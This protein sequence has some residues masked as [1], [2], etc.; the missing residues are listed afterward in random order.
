MQQFEH[1]RII[2]A[3]VSECVCVRE[4]EGERV[5]E[6]EGGRERGLKIIRKILPLEHQKQLGV[7]IIIFSSSDILHTITH[8]I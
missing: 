1:A 5:S 3:R 4:R 8:I 7:T 2:C 6:R